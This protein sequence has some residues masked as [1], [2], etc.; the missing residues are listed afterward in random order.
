MGAF[1]FTFLHDNVSFLHGNVS[2]VLGFLLRNNGVC[3]VGLYCRQCCCFYIIINAVN[4]IVLLIIICI[5]NIIVIIIIILAFFFVFFVLPLFQCYRS[6]QYI[7]NAYYRSLTFYD[8]YHEQPCTLLYMNLI[9]YDL[10]NKICAKK[11]CELTKAV[12]EIFSL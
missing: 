7:S 2:M 4:F 12:A 6:C 3:F 5:T 9:L 10:Q 11:D 1:V 8:L